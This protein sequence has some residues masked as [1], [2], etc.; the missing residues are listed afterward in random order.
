MAPLDTVGVW[1]TEDRSVREPGRHPAHHPRTVTNRVREK[2]IRG[3][4]FNVSWPLQPV[5]SS[6]V[7]VGR[8]IM[9]GPSEALSLNI[10]P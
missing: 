10:D 6:A 2:I 1:T 7:S 5:A 3:R 4:V 8:C 9:S